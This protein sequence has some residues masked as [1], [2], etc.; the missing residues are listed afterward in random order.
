VVVGVLE[1]AV[2]DVGDG[3]EAAVRVPRR[4]LG[5]A[6][7]VLDLAR[8]PGTPGSDLAFPTTAGNPFYSSPGT[9]VSAYW[10]A[11]VEGGR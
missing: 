2:D 4:A 11:R 7:R 8:W 3:L 1:G 6:G 9:R 10:Y 5:L